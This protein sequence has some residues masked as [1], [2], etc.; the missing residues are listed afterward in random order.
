MKFCKKLLFCSTLPFALLG[1]AIGGIY[2]AI[3]AGIVASRGF[4]MNYED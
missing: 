4:Y 2:I 1:F 3:K